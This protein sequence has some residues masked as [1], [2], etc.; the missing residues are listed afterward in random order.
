[1]TLLDA[2]GHLGYISLFV[3]SQ[4]LARHNKYGW[5]ARLVGE[6]IWVVI[7]FILGMTSIWLWGIFFIFFN[8][9]YGFYKWNKK[10]KLE[11]EKPSSW[12][13]EEWD[14]Q[15]EQ[16]HR[17]RKRCQTKFDYLSREGNSKW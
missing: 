12:T 2:V 3:G 10:E 8:D 14:Y 6:A 5:L 15:R 7:G 13:Q 1:M 4:L 17:L 16:D 9:V 11:K